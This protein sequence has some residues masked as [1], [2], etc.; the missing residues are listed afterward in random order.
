M[1]KAVE[2]RMPA[3]VCRV[4]GAR[5]DAGMVTSEYAMGIVAAVA[6]AVVLY[7]VVTSGEVSA[8]LQAIVKQ[9]LDAR[10]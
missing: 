9:A 3:L 4:R 1:Y 8:E 6:F 10:M 2:A 5:R 7:K